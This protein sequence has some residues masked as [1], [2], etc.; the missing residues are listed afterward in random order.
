MRECD[1]IGAPVRVGWFQWHCINFASDEAFT[2]LCCW[3]GCPCTW[4]REE[5][6][7]DGF[8]EHLMGLPLVFVKPELLEWSYVIL[9][10]LWHFCSNWL[11][12]WFVSAQAFWQIPSKSSV[13]RD[14]ALGLWLSPHLSLCSSWNKVFRL[15]P[16]KING[17]VTSPTVLRRWNT[18]S[19]FLIL[20]SGGF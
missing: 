15:L 17:N 10:L 4:G 8:G 12:W 6:M 14:G 9:D 2:L 16:W 11:L 19:R 7:E 20:A 5:G 1:W 13:W 3:K 18:L